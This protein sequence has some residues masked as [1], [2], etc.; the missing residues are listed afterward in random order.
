MKTIRIDLLSHARHLNQPLTGFHRWAKRNGYRLDIRDCTRGTEYRM[1]KTALVADVDGCRLVYDMADGY[2]SPEAMEYLLGRCDFYFKRSFS[3][4]ANASMGTRKVY[5]SRDRSPR[6][7]TTW[8]I[9]RRRNASN[10]SA[11]CWR[12]RKR[13]GPCRRTTGSIPGTG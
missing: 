13:S 2:Q 6:A 12:I 9:R 1:K 5:P 4:S 10:R 7:E 8:N 11:S 3:E